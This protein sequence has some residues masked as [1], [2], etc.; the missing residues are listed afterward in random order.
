[1]LIV[2]YC[3]AVTQHSV[4]PL[5]RRT[6]FFLSPKMSCEVANSPFP[7][8]GFA[9][10]FDI[11]G[12]HGDSKVDFTSLKEFNYT[13][14][15]EDNSFVDP[16]NLSNAGSPC[17]HFDPSVAPDFAPNI[18]PNDLNVT[19][20]FPYFQSVE[21]PFNNH[22]APPHLQNQHLHRR[23]VSEPPDGALLHHHAPHLHGLV[24]LHRDGQPLG[25]SRVNAPLIKRAKQSRAQPYK[26]SP[27]Q[28]QPQPH[29]NRYQ[30]RRTHT[31]STHLPPTSVP[32]GMPVDHSHQPQQ[33]QIHHQPFQ[34]IPHE[35]QYVSSRV[36]TPAPEAIDPFLDASPMPMPMVAPMVSQGAFPQSHTGNETPTS[37]SVTIKM[38][39]DELRT[40]ITEVV[41]KAVQGLQVGT[42]NSTTTVDGA[43][44]ELA[45]EGAME[46]MQANESAACVNTLT[47]LEA[48]DKVV[49]AAAA[50]DGVGDVQDETE[51]WSAM[52]E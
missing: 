18:Y 46:R 51:L 49:V 31:Q 6:S 37:N 29:Q 7:D 30:L 14:G 28:P 3:I 25:V 19:Q 9:S 50:V 40:M 38:G 20:A 35:P 8:P 47:G 34:Q 32:H 44:Q 45:V 15:T 39:V 36:C 12:A 52:K 16:Q 27:R 48:G 10:P 22:I 17:G 24:T 41:Q 26:R 2:I 5:Q 13:F 11:D 33:M 4:T 1:M 23:S 42:S 21:Q 43:A